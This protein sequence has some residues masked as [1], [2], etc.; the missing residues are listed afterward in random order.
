M[1][2]AAKSP[3]VLK[4][5]NGMKWSSRPAGNLGKAD[6][7]RAGRGEVVIREIKNNFRHLVVTVKTPSAFRGD[8]GELEDHGRRGPV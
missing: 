3:P 8:L 1:T 7:D 2:A 5:L 6:V 4:S